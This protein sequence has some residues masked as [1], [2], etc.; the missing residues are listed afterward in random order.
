MAVEAPPLEDAPA[1]LAAW[2]AWLP[3]LVL[4]SMY[5]IGFVTA[6]LVALLLKRTL[7]RGETPVFVME[8]PSFKLP[9]FR[10]VLRRMVEAGWSFV[11]RAGTMI[12]AS[13]IVIWALLYF[14]NHDAAGRSME[15][16]LSTLREELDALPKPD[17]EA[18]QT[19]EGRT[20]KSAWR[21]W[22]V[23]RPGK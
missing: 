23:S 8:M 5:L 4:F 2:L 20:G 13:M 18:A 10:T 6:P 19:E 14:P 7:L 3:G 15:T 17:K 16:R 11:R 9:Q 21:P 22:P 12:L 1:D